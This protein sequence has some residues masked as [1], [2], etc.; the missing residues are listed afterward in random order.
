MK[1]LRAKDSAFTEIIPIDSLHPTILFGWYEG[2]YEN[3]KRSIETI[4]LLNPIVVWQTTPQQWKEWRG[5]SPDLLPVPDYLF[6]L[7]YKSVYLVMCGNNRLQVAKDLGY[8]HVE[9]RRYTNTND[10]SLECNRQRKS[11]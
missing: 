1:I 4:G 7:K 8:D 6:E 5:N 10:V 2:D 11:W 3:I 9:V